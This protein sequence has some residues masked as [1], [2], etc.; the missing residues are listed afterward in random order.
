[1]PVL[2]NLEFAEGWDLPLAAV[3]GGM[4]PGSAVLVGAGSQGEH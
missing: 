4:S 2:P 3:G 1:M